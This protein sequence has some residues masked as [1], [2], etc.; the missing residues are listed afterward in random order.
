M[1][2]HL[3]GKHLSLN[4]FHVTMHGILFIRICHVLCER[5]SVCV[6]DCLIDVLNLP[7]NIFFVCCRVRKENTNSSLYFFCFV[8]AAAVAADRTTRNHF[9]E[10]ISLF[11]WEVGGGRRSIVYLFSFRLEFI[12]FVCLFVCGIEMRS[13]LGRQAIGDV[14]RFSIRWFNQFI[15]NYSQTKWMNLI[16][17]MT[18]GAQPHSHTMIITIDKR[19]N[20]KRDVCVVSVWCW[21]LLRLIF[22]HSFVTI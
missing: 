1:G 2:F 6:C 12:S 18:I 13:N 21:C 3:F 9:S 4:A 10:T 15:L 19:R 8:C 11:V 17:D 5:R 7:I 22:E 16:T 20:V 14:D